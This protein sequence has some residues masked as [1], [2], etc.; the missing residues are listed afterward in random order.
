MYIVQCTH[1]THAHSLSLSVSLSGSVEPGHRA[2]FSSY[3]GVLYSGDDFALK[4]YLCGRGQP[5]RNC[6][7]GS[8]YTTLS[9]ETVYMKASMVHVPPATHGTTVTAW[10]FPVRC[11]M[12]SLRTTG[13]ARSVCSHPVSL[14]NQHSLRVDSN[15]VSSD[16][17]CVHERVVAMSYSSLWY[18][19]T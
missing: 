2:S 3:P 6:S 4:L 17:L 15:V 18:V 5:L 7:A 8:L 19:C 16:R 9:K 12:R 11:L 1:Y 10:T 13:S 14:L